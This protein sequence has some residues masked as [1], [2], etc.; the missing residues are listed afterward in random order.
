VEK[1]VDVAPPSLR[2]E[3]L[4][5]AAE[6]RRVRAELAANGPLFE[7]YHPRMA[8]VHRRNAA[9]LVRTGSSRPIGVGNGLLCVAHGEDRPERLGFAG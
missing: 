5:M 6:D 8:G 4:A 9:R 7:S 3:L 2:A 1:A